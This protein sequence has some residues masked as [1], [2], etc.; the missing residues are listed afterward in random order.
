[1]LKLVEYLIHGR[2][3]YEALAK[4]LKPYQ[5]FVCLWSSLFAD[6][7]TYL[8]FKC[9]LQLDNFVPYSHGNTSLISACFCITLLFALSVTACALGF[10]TWAFARTIYEIDYF[11]KNRLR[12]YVFV[13]LIVGCKFGAGFCHAYVDDSF[14]RSLYL[15]IL[16]GCTL[17]GLLLCWKNMELKLYRL[18]YLFVC[19][20]KVLLHI[21]LFI[22]VRFPGFLALIERSEA[23]NST[24]LCMFLIFLPMLLLN[25][26]SKL[27]DISKY[28]SSPPKPK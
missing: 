18:F 13:T 21:R 27:I 20:F 23:E 12:S 15:L 9:F 14:Y 5:S 22:Q 19:T 16:N 26:G 28:F 3:S 10:M 8:S 4:V 2:K 17:L 7:M 25:V 1:M 24:I 6:N 11:K